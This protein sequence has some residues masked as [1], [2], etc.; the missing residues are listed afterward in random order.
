MQLEAGDAALPDERW[1]SQCGKLA[2]VD[3]TG[4]QLGLFG[5]ATFIGGVELLA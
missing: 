4:Q 5:E 3:G 1:R 2:S